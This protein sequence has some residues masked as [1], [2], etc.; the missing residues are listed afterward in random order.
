MSTAGVSGLIVQRRW[1]RRSWLDRRR[2]GAGSEYGA[3]FEAA[4]RVAHLRA[5]HGRALAGGV[6]LI[7]L[8]QVTLGVLLRL[9]ALAALGPAALRAVLGLVGRRPQFI[10]RTGAPRPPGDA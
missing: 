6:L 4:R 8:V 3:A 5:Q 10:Q 2:S 9:A 7:A 1:E